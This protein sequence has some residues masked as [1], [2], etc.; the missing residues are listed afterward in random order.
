L[1]YQWVSATQSL[2]DMHRRAHTANPVISEAN[3]FH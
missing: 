3:F 1:N 2:I